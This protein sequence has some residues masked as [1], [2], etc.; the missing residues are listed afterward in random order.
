MVTPSACN[1]CPS[2]FVFAPAGTDTSTAAWPAAR[3]SFTGPLTPLTARH[4]LDAGDDPL[5]RPGQAGL[6]RGSEPQHRDN[7][8]RPVR[9]GA[10]AT[11]ASSWLVTGVTVAR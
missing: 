1:R 10:V 2:R 5:C 8:G 11:A 4:L 3:P 7:G 6:R 9:H